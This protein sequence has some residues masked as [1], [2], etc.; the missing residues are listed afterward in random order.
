MC[1]AAKTGTKSDVTCEDDDEPVM[2]GEDI[3]LSSDH[4]SPLIEANTT[5]YQSVTNQQLHVSSQ[6]NI[7]MDTTAV[8]NKPDI[9]PSVARQQHRTHLPQGVLL[10]ELNMFM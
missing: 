5:T 1:F 3:S 2:T 10:Y 8:S 4:Q 9:V 6:E 7:T